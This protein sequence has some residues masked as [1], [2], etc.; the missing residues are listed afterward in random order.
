[1][2]PVNK[3]AYLDTSAGL[4]SLANR[5]DAPLEEVRSLAQRDELRKFFKVTTGP[6]AP[7]KRSAAAALAMVKAIK[8]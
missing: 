8:V 5:F 3:P 1:V 4:R 2:A 7:Q 6:E